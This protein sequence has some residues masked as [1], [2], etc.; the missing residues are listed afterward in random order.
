MSTSE[1][2]YD[3]QNL[4]RSPGAASAGM[5]EERPDT[6]SMFQ[7][8]R[9]YKAAARAALVLLF[10]PNFKT[11]VNQA[12]QVLGESCGASRMV[13]IE[14]HT[15][16]NSE[17][18]LISL[19]FYWS[20]SGQG[21]NAWT[22][23]PCPPSLTAHLNSMQSGQACLEPL[24]LQPEAA[25]LP[26][27]MDL[28][29]VLPILVSDKLWGFLGIEAARP[30]PTWPA[31]TIEFLQLA[32]RSFAGAIQQKSTEKNLR[33]SETRLKTILNNI[34]AGVMITDLA[35]G[36][37]SEVNLTALKMI[38]AEKDFVIGKQAA[39]FITSINQPASPAAKSEHALE[40]ILITRHG[41]QVPIIIDA[42]DTLIETRT[43]RIATF[44]SIDDLK[45]IE[46]I[47]TEQRILA[48]AL[49]ETASILTQSLNLRE[50]LDCILANVGRVIPNDAGNIMLIDDDLARM[51]A[52]RGYQNLGGEDRVMGQ[53]R[54]IQDMPNLLR[55]SET[56]LPIVVSDTQQAAGWVSYKN[57][58]WIHSYV[59]A[60]IRHQGKTIG[61]LNLNSSIAGFYT[62]EHASRLLAFADQA[63]IAITN[64]R[65]FENAQ[66]EIAIR[67]QAEHELQQAK[68]DLEMRVEERTAELLSANE[69][70]RV[71]LARRQQ[72]EKE[73][74]AERAMLASRIEERTAELS[75]A[76]AELA[77]ASL[78][79][80]SFLASMSHELRTP[81][82]AILNISETL[83]EMVFG[84]LNEAQ[85]RSVRTVEESGRHL[86]ALINDILDLSK[87]GAGK[88][89]IIRDDVP[90]QSVCNTSIQLV[91][92]A[93][94][95]KSIILIHHIDPG[96]R[97]VWADYRR[98]K[99][100]LVNLLSNAVKFTPHGGTVGLEV[101][102]D[103]NKKQVQFIVWDTGIGMPEE[104]LKYLFKPFVQLDNSLARQYEGTG[105]GLALAYH[106]IELHG[107]GIRVKSELG[108]GSRFIV[109]LN[110]EIAGRERAEAPTIPRSM[111]MES[112]GPANPTRRIIQYLNELGME[113]E[114]H[115]V[116]KE[117]LNSLEP[118]K[119]DLIVLEGGLLDPQNSYQ[120]LKHL[121]STHKH[122]LIVIS[123]KNETLEFPRLPEMAGYLPFPFNRQQLRTLVRKVSGNVTA[124]L[125][126]KAAIVLED[127]QRTDA[128]SPLVLVADDNKTAIDLIEDY[129]RIKGYRTISAFNGAEAIEKTREKKPDLILM[130]I[131][132]PGIDGLEAT[133][134]IRAD[135][136]IKNTPIIA[137][138][139]LAM[140]RDR[141]ICL[142]AGANEYLS[143]PV[144]M[145]ELV[146]KMEI[147]LNRKPA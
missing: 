101:V 144:S 83:Q 132:M 44:V 109:T 140:A 86:L 139:A 128:G 94:R 81:L 100:V 119:E 33:E 56:G 125:C 129:L 31:E 105:L 61:F 142:Q 32:A 108:K 131:Q 77:K 21:L 49:R 147:Q 80:D 25:E 18:K 47:E 141:E 74:E 14:Y 36:L 6:A 136:Y 93:A 55:M 43:Y 28:T 85:M 146:E 51:A 134:R 22:D 8:E 3:S 112:D 59:S 48:Q 63:A 68:H 137:L 95:K 106:I 110:L 16:A 1:N 34:Q 12:L 73:L 102:S 107:G 124:S 62:P 38:A 84:E 71:E 40:H 30:E 15:R 114:D 118:L 91:E 10:T 60:P 87:I 69:Q 66:N 123:E 97:H 45:K 116:R 133:R 37:I 27:E 98:L 64:A 53:V 79:K 75:A 4:T 76:N 70:L 5:A 115:L 2:H 39:Q 52:C 103:L 29:L 130:D 143:K 127:F 145:R 46:Q 89:E 99:Q 113:T 96:L 7:P 122:P 19:R 54:P 13:L 58:A 121:V 17:E 41:N 9:L 50:V 42:V 20:L 104:S 23:L 24:L 57:S 11:A 72:V 92:E 88:F 65:L 78:L 126:R 138:T 90:I 35:S 26:G 67:K 120:Q 117:H 135:A 111:E 82:N